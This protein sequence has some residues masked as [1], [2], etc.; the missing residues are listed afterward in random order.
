MP[1]PSMTP[2]FRG[3]S[4]PRRVLQHLG[5]WAR[6]AT[7]EPPPSFA[8]DAVTALADHEAR[9][10]ALLASNGELAGALA[11]AREALANAHEVLAR[12]RESL[13]STQEALAAAEQARR[14]QTEFMV[15][16]AHDLCNPLAPEHTTVADLERIGAAQPLLGQAQDALDTQVVDMASIV[17][18]A[19]DAFRATISARRQHLSVTVA[20]SRPEV[21]G[22]PVRLAQALCNLLENASKYTQQG[23][24]I[25]VSVAVEEGL[26]ELTVADNGQGIDAATLPA[27]F[28]PF[29]RGVDAPDSECAG[30][31]LGLTLARQFIESH[32]GQVAARSA[33]IGLGSEFLIR[34]PLARCGCAFGAV[35]SANG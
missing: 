20:G 32:G 23:G 35:P 17:D 14:Q 21:A 11:L 19:V 12:T 6:R 26:V 9:H 29:V 27:V 8:P 13:E 25:Q 1:M 15:V 16:L 18:H 4:A 3:V 7:I 5:T 33:G 34:L 2:R 31:G 10:Q 24:D 28:D 22:D 30:L